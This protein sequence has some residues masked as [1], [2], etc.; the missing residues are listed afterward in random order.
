MSVNDRIRADFT[1]ADDELVD[2]FEAYIREQEADG[3]VFDRHETV[4]EFYEWHRPD[5]VTDEGL[6]AEIEAALAEC[7]DYRRSKMDCVAPPKAPAR[8]DEGGSKTSVGGR[9]GLGASGLLRPDRLDAGG[10]E[11]AMA[12]S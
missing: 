12:R 9:G 1:A 8:A 7:D 4:T 3:R 2:P 11:S 5:G 6:D 10:H